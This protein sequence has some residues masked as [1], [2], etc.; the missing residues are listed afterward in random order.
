[1]TK[2]EEII[3]EMQ[4]RK[5]IFSKDEFLLV[6]WDEGCKIL[7]DKGYKEPLKSKD[8][9]NAMYERGLEVIKVADALY[10]EYDKPIT[11]TFYNKDEE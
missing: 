5:I 2:L 4:R 3:Q 7:I 10:D 8:I 6:L 9:V 1:M 11:M